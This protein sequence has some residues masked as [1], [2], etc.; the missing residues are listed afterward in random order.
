MNLMLLR[1]VNAFKTVP[2]YLQEHGVIYAEMNH[3][4]PAYVHWR[5]LREK[6]VA[7]FEIVK[8]L[9]LIRREKV[10]FEVLSKLLVIEVGNV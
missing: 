1:N 5:F 8:P 2:E 4:H 7:W 3:R 6:G 9:E 10:K